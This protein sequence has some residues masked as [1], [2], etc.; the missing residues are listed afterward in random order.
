MPSMYIPEP[1]LGPVKRVLFRCVWPVMKFVMGLRRVDKSY[2]TGVAM[3]RH[4]LVE[5]GCLDGAGIGFELDESTLNQIPTEGPV[6]IVSNHPY[7]MAEGLLQAHIIRLV[8]GDF[9]QLVNEMLA[10]FPELARQYIFVNAFE[11]E[12]ARRDNASPLRASLDWLKDGHLLATF[13]SGTVSHSTWSNLTPLDPPWNPS[14]VMLAKRSGAT[15]V[16][17]YFQGAHPWYFQ[18]FGLLWARF[19]TVLIPRCYAWQRGSTITAKIGRPISPELLSALPNRS[20]AIEYLRSRVYLLK[21]RRSASSMTLS[22]QQ[23]PTP[24]PSAHPDASSRFAAEIDRLDDSQHLCTSGHLSVHL[25]SASQI[26]EILKEIGRLREVTFRAVGEG[27]GNDVDLDRYDETYRHLFIWNASDQEVV[28]SYRLGLTDEIRSH[29]GLEGFYTRT[30]FD[31]DE[32]MLDRIG[33]A[34]EL[35]R[36][37]IRPEYQ[38]GFKPLMLLWRGISNFAAQQR[39]YRHCFGVVSL[40]NDYSDTSKTLM[41]R[42]L[43]QRYRLEDYESLVTART[44]WT[45]ESLP[46]GADIDALLTG[47]QSIEDVDDLVRDIESDGLGVP[48]LVRQYLKLEARLLAPFNLDR[49]FA[50]VIDGLMLVDFMQVERRIAHFYLGEDLATAFRTHHGFPAFSKDD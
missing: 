5:R 40:S 29:A 37:F 16:P 8:R 48:V 10:C 36:S 3:K 33:D 45:G 23:D 9:K 15:V 43:E 47:C 27:T 11:T 21:S 38:R 30:L 7:G 18:F 31:Y 22:R 24:G 32:A 2:A 50:D 34:I 44:P 28:G 39:R 14:V 6:L 25:A 12:A 13:P 46:P 26:P 1:R 20:A 35:G 41:T 19:R 4:E 42:F 17:L 49:S